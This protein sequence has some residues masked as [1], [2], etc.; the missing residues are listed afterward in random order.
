MFLIFAASGAV[1]GSIRWW[2]RDHR[3][4]HRYTDTNKDPYNA[5]KGLLFSH[6]GWMVLKHNPNEVGRVD[7]SDLNADPMIVIQHK[8]YGLF[9]I[10]M[11]FVFPTLV[12]GLGWGDYW[13]SE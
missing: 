6:I 4:H 9:A 1:E 12:A 7:I 13:V 10:M 2:C 3:A 8:Y 11:G 5:H